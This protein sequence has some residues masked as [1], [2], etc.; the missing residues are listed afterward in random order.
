MNFVVFASEVEGERK[1]GVVAEE[2]GREKKHHDA[3]CSCGR[4]GCSKRS[5]CVASYL[6]DLV[7]PEDESVC[8]F[9]C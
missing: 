7:V 9:F 5:K 6:F 2:E 3:K 8:L 1:V 4:F